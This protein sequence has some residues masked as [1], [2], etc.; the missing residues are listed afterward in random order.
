[1][2]DYGRGLAHWTTTT[3]RNIFASSIP[4]KPLD[5]PFAAGSAQCPGS[6]ERDHQLS[7]LATELD[8]ARRYCDYL[9]SAA[10]RSNALFSEFPRWRARISRQDVLIDPKAPNQYG[11]INRTGALGTPGPGIITSHWR[12]RA[13]DVGRLCKY[14]SCLPVAE[15]SA[16]HSICFTPEAPIFVCIPGKGYVGVGQ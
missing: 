16:G 5:K 15:M 4:T 14:D 6:I 1:V 10:F 2:L 8:S 9:A 11:Q 7:S 13:A 12:G 3:S